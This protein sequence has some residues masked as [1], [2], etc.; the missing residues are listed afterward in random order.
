MYKVYY[1][2]SKLD[3]YIPMY[4]GATKLSLKD[5]L[6]SHFRELNSKYPTKKD[7]WKK[8]RRKE[9]E[10]FLIEENISKELI[11][12]REQFWINYW[13][14][15]N[16]KLTNSNKK[17]LYG[18]KPEYTFSDR[19]EINNKIKE[20][21]KYRTK[22][23]V[24]LYKNGNFY[25][26]YNKIN[27]CSKELGIKEESIINSAKNI[28]QNSKF[29]FIYLSE[30]DENK[31]YSYLNK[32]KR[33]IPARISEKCRQQNLKVLRTPCYIEDIYT[34]E[35]L[36]FDSYTKCASF[37]GLKSS[38]IYSNIKRNSTCLKKYKIYKK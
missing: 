32:Y 34:K 20:S 35:K 14:K 30:Y 28:R 15:L 23:I 31:D 29:N 18:I 12:E 37:L 8:S 6:K 13:R 7:N 9:V 21:I 11:A 26:Q 10:I 16:D 2:T 24:V 5:R 33:N 36:E 19:Q 4:I 38:T 3:F 27:E 17:I 1:L 22:S 25:K